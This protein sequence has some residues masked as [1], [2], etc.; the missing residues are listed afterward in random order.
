MEVQAMF[1]DLE[2]AE[3][4]SEP[5][6]RLTTWLRTMRRFRNEVLGQVA[7]D[8]S[9]VARNEQEIFTPLEGDVCVALTGDN[10]KCDIVTVWDD[11][12]EDDGAK[13][14]REG[15]Q[16]V[17]KKDQAQMVLRKDHKEKYTERTVLVKS[18]KGKPKPYP[19]SSLRLM[20]EGEK[21]KKRRLQGK[22]V[23]NPY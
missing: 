17:Q 19:S 18:G 7:A 11:G 15:D 13:D 3:A 5:L 6:D 10:S 9:S 4:G 8:R 22:E 1:R 2:E 16:A 21:R 12:E 23:E 20:V 14:D